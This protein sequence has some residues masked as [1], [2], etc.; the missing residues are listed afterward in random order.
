M[1]YR[2]DVAVPHLAMEGRS[3]FGPQQGP[4]VGTSATCIREQ[5]R[6]THLYTSTSSSIALVVVVL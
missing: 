4:E 6:G 2:R 3:A 5:L 1:L